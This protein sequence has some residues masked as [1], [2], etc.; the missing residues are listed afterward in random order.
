MAERR[1]EKGPDAATRLIEIVTALVRELHPSRSLEVTLDRDLDRDLQFDSL[2]RA[3]L[4]VRLERAFAVALPEQLLATAETPRDLLRALATARPG[5]ARGRPISVGTSLELEA[6]TVP[7]N[8]D[9]LA[10]VLAWHLERQPERP[11]VH[12]YESGDAAPQ[13]VTYRDLDRAGRGVAAALAARGFSPGQT[14]AI[15]LPT[16]RDYLATFFG[17]VLAGGVPV[18]IYP[19]ARPSQLEEHLRRHAR[20]LEAA[21]TE[22]LVTVPEGQT[23]GRLLRGQVD[24]L[25]YVLTATDLAGDPEAFAPPPIKATDTAFV[26]FTSGSTAQPKGVVLTHQNILSNIRAMGEAIRAE[27]SDIFVSWLPLYHDMGLIGAWLGSMYFGMQAVLMSPLIFLAHPERWLWAIHEHGGTI[28]AAPNFA[29]ELCLSKVPDAVLEGLNLATW[30]RAFNGAE[31]VSPSTVRRFSDRFAAYGF[32]AQAMAPV[33]GLAEAAVGLAFPPL[34]S[35]A[36]IDRIRRGP[37]EREGRAHP[38]EKDDATSLE[39]VA[40]GRPL[41]GYEIRIVGPTGRELGEREVGRLE[42][43]GPS[44]T[45]GYL[46]NPTASEALFDGDWLDSGDLAYIAGADVYLTSRVRDVIIRAG[47]N[48]YPYEVEEAVGDTDGVRK[49]C[50]AVFGSTDPA[51]GTEKLVVVAETREEEPLALERMAAAIGTRV[52]DVLGMPADDIVLAPPRTVLKTSS[53]KIRRAATRKVY[54]RGDIGKRARPVWWQVTRLALSSTA[55]RWRGLRRA[56]A[57]ICYG[58]YVEVIFF[59]IVIPVWIA[60]AV[61]P[62]GPR[63]ALI[64]AAARALFRVA[65]IPFFVDGI[66]RLPHGTGCVYVS[67]HASYLDGVVAVAGLPGTFSFA[68]KAELKER[69]VSRIFLRRIGAR[70]VERDDVVKG[71]ADARAE[72]RAAQ[73]GE[74]L[75]FFPEGGLTREPGLRP[76]HLGAFAA[77]AEAGVPVVPVTLRG[78]R[79]ILRGGSWFPRRG[80]VTLV[81]G[82]PVN[83]DGSDWA[84]SVR[85]RDA[86]RARMLEHLGEP[87][88]SVD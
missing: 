47:R 39:F 28:S 34:D 69:F 77:A 13:L 26:Q 50:V 41:P 11:H 61:L 66:D 27:S 12:L 35:G 40:C 59:L 46:R 80:T 84:A 30:R 4:L 57:E 65:R 36:V 42:F 14:V 9:T 37:F 38:A 43:L 73:R 78:T 52:N 55:S 44:A 31:P 60:V 3:E 1:D 18:P 45:S 72:V 6:G 83:P 32:R 75:Y 85:L 10:D 49:G 71:L 53:G 67:N 87:D 22:H 62:L 23:A 74:S 56:A 70:F 76:F 7:E 82:E 5:T 29:F 81:V 20:I 15:M 79:S 8:A 86:T 2:A 19:P 21:E 54:E 25:R 16:S 64:R 68:A 58:V 24:C 51:S 88:I 63:W 33:Y 48:I 17:I